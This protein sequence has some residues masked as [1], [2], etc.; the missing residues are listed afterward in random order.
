MTFEEQVFVVN[1]RTTNTYT[2]D[3]LRRTTK[4]QGA[5]TVTFVWDGSDYLGE[6]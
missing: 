3:G 6:Y 2:G 5:S 4:K 1:G